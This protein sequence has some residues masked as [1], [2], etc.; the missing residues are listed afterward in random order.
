MWL[1][2]L[3]ATFPPAHLDSWKVNPS[4][5]HWFLTVTSTIFSSTR[6][7]CRL[8]RQQEGEEGREGED[9]KEEHEVRGRKQTVL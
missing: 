2:G 7:K 9:K 4:R 6:D 3:K 1:E 5:S 8:Q